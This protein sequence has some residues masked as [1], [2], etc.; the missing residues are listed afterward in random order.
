[1]PMEMKSFIFKV[2][3]VYLS[4]ILDILTLKKIIS[5]FPRELYGKVEI[6]EETCALIIESKYPFR[7]AK[8]LSKY[9]WSIIEHSPF[10]KGISKTPN[11]KEQ[12]RLKI[13]HS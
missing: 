1:M 4:Q 10:A 11:F 6:M 13:L 3:M 8:P 2:A 9:I 7:N 5:L 12:V